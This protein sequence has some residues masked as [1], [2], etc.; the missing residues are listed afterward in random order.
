MS[1]LTEERKNEISGIITI[2]L[3]IIIGLSLLARGVGK[4]GEVLK[5]FFLSTLGWG[6]YLVPPLLW[7]VG[8]RL[9]KEKAL[10]F[11]FRWV[12]F[13]LDYICLLTLLHWR[14]PASQAVKIG[15]EGDGGGV[16]GAFLT[17]VLKSWFGPVGGLTLLVAF[18]IIGTL[19][20]FDILLGNLTGFIKDK[21]LQLL[22]RL[23][24]LRGR[25]P[26]RRRA[27]GPEE[28]E[29]MALPPG[30]VADEEPIYEEE[31]EQV[32][33]RDERPPRKKQD[34]YNE[35]YRNPPLTLLKKVRIGKNNPADQREVLKETL[36]NFGVEA[37]VQ[38]V[39]HGPTITRYELQPQ[40][41]V[42]V[43]KIVNL[44]DDIA[45]ALAAPEV[46]IEA[47]IPGKAAVGIEIPHKDN[48]LVSL[49]EI[50]DTPEFQKTNHTLPVVLGKDVAGDP[51]V[52]DLARMPHLLVAGATG[53][54]KSVFINSLVLSIL[55]KS[56]PDQ[57]RL[58]LVDP[59]KVEMSYY[60]NLPHL[61]APVVT[62]S[63]KAAG[64]LNLIVEEMEKRYELFS[65]TGARGIDGYNQN[66]LENNEDHDDQK[67]LLMPYIIVIIDELSD[68]MM[69]APN[70]VEDAICRLAQM[71]R[72][73]GIHLVLATQRPSVD[74]ITG[75]IKAN[76]PSRLSFA[77][78]SQTDSRTIL[79]MGGAEKLMGN[80]DMLFLPVGSMKP[81]RIQGAF[82][83]IQEI[84]K[85]VNFLQGEEEQD[86]T[87]DLEQLAEEPSAVYREEKDELYEDAVKLV[88]ENDRASISMLQRRLH[89]GY[90]R[91]ARLID[92]M[93]ED[94][95]VGP[96]AGSK[97]RDVL[98][99]TDDL[100]K[101]LAAADEDEF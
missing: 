101:I 70:E 72:A 69:V 53:T 44:A 26:G 22:E 15:L 23:R 61:I 12:G 31:D 58:L 78:S 24:A 30:L 37:T 93:E 67:D 36:A 82:V 96:Y 98:V 45:L 81:K 11:T 63:K 27:E 13:I 32:A 65:E 79:D 71:A 35:A 68:L 16:L 33:T 4:A 9:I 55:Y 38:K 41:G 95:I 83:T 56:H 99:Q 1:G 86:Y 29:I 50:L 74:V 2:A 57:V 43:S 60:K 80:G 100:D 88:V 40:P 64:V 47:P 54:G 76:I 90:T 75:L 34:K 18:T 51:V 42:K 87:L 77:V 49:R 10:S 5:V 8:Y 39:T 19:L 21:Y 92:M 6:G 91:A 94:S 66:I 46:R 28:E 25:L 7:Y 89:I 97:P 85:V 17:T 48:S 3:G 20:W 14:Y 73:A 62:D 84:K 52:V 59:K